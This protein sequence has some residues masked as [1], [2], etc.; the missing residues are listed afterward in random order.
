MI[1]RSS[2]PEANRLLQ[3]GIL[4]KST[5][6]F[7]VPVVPRMT[8]RLLIV[9]GG[10]TKRARTACLL[11]PHSFTCSLTVNRVM[12]WG[13]PLPNQ[14]PLS[15]DCH[16]ENGWWASFPWPDRPRH[17]PFYRMPEMA[18]P[19]LGRKHFL[20]N[21]SAIMLQLTCLQASAAPD[22]NYP[23]FSPPKLGIIL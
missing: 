12:V 3:R 8:V 15:P 9:I 4:C 1:S 10:L 14:S 7:R 16:L 20:D 22:L 5:C 13:S 18:E 11:C 6:A 19:A 2:V 23:N 17:Q 21:S